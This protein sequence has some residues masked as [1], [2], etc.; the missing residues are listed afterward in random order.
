MWHPL[1]IRRILMNETYTGQT[2]YRRTKIQYY[3]DPVTG[4]KKRRVVDQP[5]EAWVEIPEATPAIIS[6]ELWEQVQRSLANPQRRVRS[7]HAIYPYPLSGHI[8]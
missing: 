7:G 1:T 5:K 8:R 3:R 2:I 6:Q 4:K